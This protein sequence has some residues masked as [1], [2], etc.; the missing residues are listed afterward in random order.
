[1]T[2]LHWK[3]VKYKIEISS[4]SP[5]SRKTKGKIYDSRENNSV[6]KQNMAKMTTY[7]RRENIWKMKVERKRKKKQNINQQ[8]K[9]RN[10][11]PHFFLQFGLLKLNRQTEGQNIYRIDDHWSMDLWE[12]IRLLTLIAWLIDQQPKYLCNRWPL[13]RGIFTKNILYLY[14]HAF[15]NL[16]DNRHMK[17]L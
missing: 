2:E 13:I 15:C 5:R 10:L 6:F 4:I 9:S 12:K 17:Y 11:T 16:T 7:I 3:V 8:N 1:M 14:I